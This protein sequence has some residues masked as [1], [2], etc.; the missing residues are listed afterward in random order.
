MTMFAFDSIVQLVATMPPLV[1]MIRD[2]ELLYTKKLTAQEKELGPGRLKRTLRG[3]I[4]KFKPGERILFV[5]I[6]SQPY[7]ARIKQLLHVYNR[8][9]LFSRPNYGSRRSMFVS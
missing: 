7:R 3:F 1:C 5:G 2:T 4:K 8:I 6:S 9:I